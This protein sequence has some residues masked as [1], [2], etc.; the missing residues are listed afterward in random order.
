MK[1]K[2]IA[3]DVAMEELQ[4]CRDTLLHKYESKN[5]K[6]GLIYISDHAI[7]RYLERIQGI[8][9]PNIESD[10]DKISA[11]LAENNIPGDEL[12]RQILP[13][14]IQRYVLRNKIKEYHYGN[15]IM[16]FDNFTLITVYE[17]NKRNQHIKTLAQQIASETDEVIVESLINKYINELKS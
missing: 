7:V 11:Y 1:E 10:V 17:N 2:I 16:I 3:L 4:K 5:N 8:E 14:Q 6:R 12:R 9:L 13:I 15:M